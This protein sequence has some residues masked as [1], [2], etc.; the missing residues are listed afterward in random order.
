VVVLDTDSLHHWHFRR[1][2][3]LLSM[4]GDNAVVLDTDSSHHWHFRRVW[5]LLSMEGDNVVV[6]DTDPPTSSAQSVEH[7]TVVSEVQGS[8]LSKGRNSS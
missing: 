7:W 4:E 8:I 6:L 1:V 5:T 2:W 3:T